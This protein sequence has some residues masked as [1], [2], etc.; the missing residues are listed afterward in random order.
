MMGAVLRDDEKSWD[1]D[2]EYFV[3]S[4]AIPGAYEI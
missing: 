4:D 2:P 1:S 3:D